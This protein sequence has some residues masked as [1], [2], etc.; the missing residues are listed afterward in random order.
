M[1][2]ARSFYFIRHGQTDWNA[3]ERFMGSTDISLNSTGR[4]QAQQA[5]E[6]VQNLPIDMIVTSSLARAKETAD[7]INKKLQLPIIVDARIK[8]RNFGD[9]EGK[10]YAEDL[11]YK[12]KILIENPELIEKETGHAPPPN[13]EPYSEFSNRILEAMNEHLNNNPEKNILFSSHGAVYILLYK[14]IFD[15]AHH[16]DNAC[17][18]LFEKQNNE[19]NFTK[20]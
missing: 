13:G 6:L 7:I 1:P 17:P 14:A 18:Y 12:E 16:P 8:E 2:I 5:L 11:A 19:W 4:E 20:L 10:T 9:L 3:E 15:K